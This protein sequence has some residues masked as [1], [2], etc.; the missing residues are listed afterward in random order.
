MRNVVYK[1]IMSFILIIALAVALCPA[2][3]GATGVSSTAAGSNAVGSVAALVGVA[4]VGVSPAGVSPAGVS[5]AGVS[6]A[7]AEITDIYSPWAEEDVFM[8]Q[9]VYN[10]GGEGV[11]SNFKG[12]LTGTKFAPM[13]E[14]LRAAF[15]S[16]YVFPVTNAQLTRGQVVGALYGALYGGGR[17]QAEAVDYFIESGLI[18]G[19]Q[20][21]DYQLD[22]ICT[23]E[24]MIVLA[25]RTYDHGIYEAGNYSKGF[26]WEIDGAA[27]KVYLLGSIHLS[28]ESIYP[29]SKP[30]EVAFARTKNLVVEADISVMSEESVAFI[31]DK[32]FFDPSGEESI[33]DHISGETYELY[34][35][36]CET[37][38]IPA[39]FY[40]YIK[41]WMAYDYLSILL[42]S[43]GNE[44]TME[45]NTAAGIDMYFL[46]KAMASGKN[47]LQLESIEFQIE[48]LSSF[49]YE[50]QEML[51]I[52][53]LQSAAPPESGGAPAADSEAP[54]VAAGQQTDLSAFLQ[55]ALAAVK[56]GDESTIVALFGIDAETE[57][58]LLREYNGKM[59]ADRDT[60]MAEK[61]AGYLEDG[62]Y[63]GDYFIVV[64]AAHLLS[65][66]SVVAK[67]TRM[68]YAV[69]RIK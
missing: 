55:E 20:P 26:F 40:D 12:N 2:A 21:E 68:G 6:P 22:E 52:E 16:E 42:M 11:Y 54:P 30:A 33:A 59:L 58:P 46:A 29:L 67:L 27:N 65:K 61:I 18:K 28:D 9:A 34:V 43:E 38:G 23:V 41:P 44:Q 63:N 57:D 56:T 47:I 1:R 35:Q 69:E 8:A 49:S 4:P 7:G 64:G 13:H 51:L 39:E 45:E 53:V 24:E 50:L 36:V 15:K 17:G 19:R 60:A 25:A 37:L 10:L 5:P 48:M 62:T 14:S 32:A 66:D 31:S 3:F